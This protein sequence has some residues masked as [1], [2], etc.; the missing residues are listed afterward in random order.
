M[1]A[2]HMAQVG[3]APPL[4]GAASLRCSIGAVRMSQVG[5]VGAPP[6]PGAASLRRSGQATPRR[7][8][9]LTVRAATPSTYGR[10]LSS[11][12]RFIQHKAEAKVF[13]AF[14]AQVYDYIVN[15]GHWTVDMRT[16]A[17][18][19]AQLGDPTLKVGWLEVPRPRLTPWRRRPGV[20][21]L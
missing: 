11:A 20:P 12:P 7:S 21:P 6:L 15:P 4:P 18:E 2:A 8:P 10:D 16:E 14:L 9:A 19:P 1:V 5:G 3:G 17:L 13:Y